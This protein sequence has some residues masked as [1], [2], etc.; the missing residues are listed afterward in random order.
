MLAKKIRGAS[1][2]KDFN[3]LCCT[4]KCTTK[5][6]I[7]YVYDQLPSTEK[8]KETFYTEIVHSPCYWPRTTVVSI[9]WAILSLVFIPR[10]M[11]NKRFNYDRF[12]NTK[13]TS[14]LLWHMVSHCLIFR[15]LVV[16]KCISMGKFSMLFFQAKAIFLRTYKTICCIFRPS[17]PPRD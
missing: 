16:N 14:T 5:S 6:R 13:Q 17:S 2:Q 10:N 9:S 4:K 15:L 11:C 12:Y 7:T 3:V 8:E 1:P